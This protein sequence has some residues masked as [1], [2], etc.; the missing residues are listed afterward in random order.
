[1]TK[2]LEQIS[3][4]SIEERIVLVEQ[5]WDNIADS[6]KAQQMKVSPDLEAELERRYQLLET[7]KTNLHS[8]EAIE[9]AL[10]SQYPV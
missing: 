8:W 1:M 5:I 2:I 9:A 10:L 6:S 7:G 3:K 4:L